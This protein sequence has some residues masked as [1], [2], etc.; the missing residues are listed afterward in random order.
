MINKNGMCDG[1]SFIR[2]FYSYKM[3]AVFCYRKS[4]ATLTSVIHKQYSQVFNC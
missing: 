3:D 1:C 2:G 4:A